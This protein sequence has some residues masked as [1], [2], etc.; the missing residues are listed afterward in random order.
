MY[1]CIIV[2]SIN[3]MIHM[4]IYIYIY[5]DSYI[6]NAASNDNNTILHTY[7]LIISK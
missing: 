6:V 4:H 5:T 1:V 2:T 7:F 3:T